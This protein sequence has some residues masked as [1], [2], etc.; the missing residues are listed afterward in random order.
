MRRLL[1]LPISI[2][3]LTLALRAQS[4][5]NYATDI[6]P[7]ILDNCT[8]CH[9][10][11]EIGPMPLTSYEEVR[12]WGFMIKYV[13]EIK[14]MPP[15]PPN[16]EYSHFLGERGLSDEE[17]SLIAEWVDNDMPLGNPDDAPDV[18]TFPDGSQ[19]GDPDLVLSFAEAY[20]HVGD[21]TDQYQIFVLP[22]GLTEDKVIKSIEFRP[23]N[24]AI[25]HHALMAV[26]NSGEAQAMDEATEEYG[27][28]SFGGGWG[29]EI[30]DQ[31]PGYVPGAR[32][33]IYPAGIGQ[34]MPAGSDLL[35]QA[36]YAPISTDQMDSSTV[37]IFFAEEDEVVDRFVE[38]HIMLPFF[39]TLV[40]GPFVI[41]ANETR[42]FHGVYEVP[43]K[44]SVMGLAPH[45]H[46]LGKN[47]L[48]YAEQPN[49]DIVNLIDV[50][51]W[52]FNWQGTYFFDRFQILE[53]GAVIHAFAEY[54]NTT[55]NPLNP[56]NPPRLVTWGEGTEDE[57]YYLPFLY[58]PYREGDEAFVFGEDGTI[59]DSEE[60]V[61]PLAQNK[62]EAIYPNPT[63]G[64]VTTFFTLAETGRVAI[65]ILDTNGKIV[66]QAVP[67]QLHLRGQYRLNL[68]LEAL[69]SGVYVVQLRGEGF[70]LTEKLVVVR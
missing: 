26:D 52:D 48:V 16:Q 54:D 24:S 7:I 11:G 19:V 33:N 42:N 36:H 23:G 6:A 60:P 57:M 35:V 3:V 40:N 44:V 27:Y 64:N 9:R 28:P 15:W 43:A 4:T 22:T 50:P 1:L 29:V 18:P 59:T 14:Y 55:D 45:M 21:N 69:P 51:E 70:T 63:S 34:A 62:L 65:N 49:G 39:G 67:N 32:P 10:A 61:L 25:V 46:L 8:V 56:N 20:T 17:I 2:C 47:W 68:D 12:N 13:T 37:N 38:T 41:P 31:Y 58:L 5:V 66:Q 30:L 53:Q